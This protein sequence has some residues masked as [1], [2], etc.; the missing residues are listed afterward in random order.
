MCLLLCQMRLVL[1]EHPVHHLSYLWLNYIGLF[2][3]TGYYLT[4]LF[5]QFFPELFPGTGLWQWCWCLLG[6]QGLGQPL[7]LQQPLQLQQ[8]VSSSQPLQ[9]SRVCHPSPALEHRPLS[10][11]LIR[12]P[13]SLL[14]KEQQ[15]KHEAH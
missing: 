2:F 1:F 4:W 6:G 15:T 12:V 13:F 10:L 11:F 5:N 8:V 3:S 14:Q 7:V 9:T